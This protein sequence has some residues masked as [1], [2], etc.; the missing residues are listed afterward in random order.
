MSAH[1]S[2][3]CVPDWRTIESVRALKGDR[4]F[5]LLLR[6]GV[7]YVLKRSGTSSG[8]EAAAAAVGT[9]RSLGINAIP[10]LPVPRR[11]RSCAF[12]AL[13]VVVAPHVLDSIGSDDELLFLPFVDALP[14]QDAVETYLRASR[15]RRRAL[16]VAIGRL[17]A[18][19]VFIDNSDRLLK[20][21]N[22]DN[23]LVDQAL[24]LHAIDQTLGG[25]VIAALSGVSDRLRRRLDRM[26][27]VEGRTSISIDLA[28]QL[29]RAGFPL[30]NED[31]FCRDVA[32]GLINGVRA[33]ATLAADEVRELVDEYSPGLGS[34]FPI[35][36][37]EFRQ[38]VQRS[39]S[40]VPNGVRTRV[41]AVKG[42]CPRPLD[43]GDVLGGQLW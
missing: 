22:L 1:G 38:A 39:E 14:L 10:A 3:A 30:G 41:A 29:K 20:G 8:M 19:D 9:I 40:G 5:Q 32:V 13:G 6:G 7:R 17:W 11:A 21:V 28:D 18:F 37:R 16:H 26:I 31:A 24:H 27:A 25:D 2:S 35:L 12:A 42:R 15:W 36:I 4:V 43:D 34:A 23:I 33:I